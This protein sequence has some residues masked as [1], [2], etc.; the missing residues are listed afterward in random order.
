MGWDNNWDLAADIPQGGCSCPLF[1]CKSNWN[2][3]YLLFNRKEVRKRTNNKLNAQM[4]P[5]PGI[6]PV[7]WWWEAHPLTTMPWFLHLDFCALIFVPW[8]LCPDFCAL[9]SVPWFLCPDF[10]ALIFVPWFSCPDF[11]ALISVPQFLHHDIWYFLLWLLW[12]HWFWFHHTKKPKKPKTNK[13]KKTRIS[14]YL[15][16]LFVVIMKSGS[17][18]LNTTCA[19]PVSHCHFKFLFSIRKVPWHFPVLITK[20]NSH[21]PVIKSM[22]FC[23][24]N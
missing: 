7:V 1:V 18:P 13:Q 11:R 15:K 4:T 3:E 6:K 5:G 10:C 17:L 19:V 12:L 14:L 2:S 20:R 23:D 22:K 21:Q 9:I 24:F 8:F 16:G